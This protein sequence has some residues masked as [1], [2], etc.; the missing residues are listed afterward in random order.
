MYVCNISVIKIVRHSSNSRGSMEARPVL[1]DGDLV[2]ALA[3]LRPP[4]IERPEHQ[5]H[6][7]TRGTLQVTQLAST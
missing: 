3:I 7:G 1:S 4:N 5:L 2:H 6:F